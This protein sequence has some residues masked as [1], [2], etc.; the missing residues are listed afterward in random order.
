MRSWFRKETS[1]AST[2]DASEPSP[3]ALRGWSFGPVDA[4]I[5]VG[6]LALAVGLCLPMAWHFRQ[7]T[8]RLDRER[9][10]GH[11]R[12]RQLDT[13]LKRLK[14][15]RAALARLRRAVERYT[16][17]VEAR[18]MV[19][20]SAVMTELSVQRPNGL[21]T[22][23]LAGDGPRFTIDVVAERPDLVTLYAER[24]RQSQF[25]DFAALPA[26]AAPATRSRLVGRV[27]G[28]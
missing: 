19:P 18:P 2:S 22:T 8:Q 21:W 10:E 13:T 24:L 15:R 7:E 11:A 27:A 26:G 6:T 3:E 9:L 12:V 4:A 17:E 23:R 5:A 14:T 28:E 1:G 20:W 25:V 16:A